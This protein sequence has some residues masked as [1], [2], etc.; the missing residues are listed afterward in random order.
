MTGGEKK[1]NISFTA[2]G[3]YCACPRKYKFH[4]IEKIRPEAIP[5]HLVFGS[6][7]DKALNEMLMKPDP[8]L[9]MDAAQKELGRLFT[10]KVTIEEKDWDHELITETTQALLLS[11]LQTTGW[12]GNSPA[13]LA[14]S[15]FDQ[16]TLG[17][18]LSESQ[19]RA[20]R[21]LVYFSFFEKIV[22]IVQ[23]FED[24]VLPQIEEI[25]SVQKYVK[26]GILDFEARLKGVD[27]V[28]ICDNKTSSRDYPPDAVKV[29]VQL[30]GYDAKVGCYIVFNKMVKK[31]RVKTCSKCGNDGTGKRHKTCDATVDF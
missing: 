21:I 17:N 2:Y 15:L 7:V 22:L 13:A 29:S 31:N 25:V 5:S 20:L 8:T 10:E 4:Y 24:Y 28:V 30:A 19:D 16:V 3:T 18:A 1:K 12:L 6:A 14:R 23:A 27:G 26:H 11:K 9:A